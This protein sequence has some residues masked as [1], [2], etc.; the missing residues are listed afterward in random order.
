M[1]IFHEFKTFK[2]KYPEDSS[3]KFFFISMLLS[4]SLII[5]ALLE[6]LFL[7]VLPSILPYTCGLFFLDH[8]SPVNCRA[9]LTFLIPYN[10]ITP[11]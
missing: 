11:A 9:V 3:M 7:L 5:S 6:R 4:E 2:H 1:I 8:S 10:L